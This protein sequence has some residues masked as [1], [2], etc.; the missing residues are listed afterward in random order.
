MFRVC[1]LF[2]FIGAEFKPV[3]LPVLAKLSCTRKSK[4][5]SIEFEVFDGRAVIC[6]VLFAEMCCRSGF[7]SLQ[8]DD[9]SSR[10][11]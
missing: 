3:S 2:F 9:S 8:R 11:G 6:R 1:H 5:C 10:S 4:G 7:N